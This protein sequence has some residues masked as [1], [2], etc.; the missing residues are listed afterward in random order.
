ML[1]DI[2]RIHYIFNLQKVQFSEIN[3]KLEVN[4]FLDLKP[5]IDV[6]YVLMFT[7]CYDLFRNLIIDKECLISK[8]LLN[9]TINNRLVLQ[10]FFKNETKDFQFA[11]KFWII[12]Y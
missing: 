6:N 11:N 12:D 5:E 2:L 7:K 3:W 10:K 4:S 9:I 8:G 1:L